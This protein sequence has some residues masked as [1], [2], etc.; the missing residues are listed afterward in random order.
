MICL[1]SFLCAGCS[2]P[3]QS[4]EPPEESIVVFK[5]L[6][7]PDLFVDIPE[8]Y[9]KTSSDAYKEFYICEDASII[10]TE[11]SRQSGYASVKDYSVQALSE[12]QQMTSSLN[13][14]NYETIR[15]VYDVYIL[16]FD[17]TLGEGDEQLRLTCMTGYLTDGKSMYIIT[18]K[19]GTDTYQNYRDGFLQVMKSANIAR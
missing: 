12:Y 14:F 6:P 1:V 15:G 17:Y 13:L 4:E 9:E 18:C 2:T 3:G 7:L 16:E 19:S 5:A 8:I 11:D 10:I